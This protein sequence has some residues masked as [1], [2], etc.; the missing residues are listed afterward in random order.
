MGGTRSAQALAD[1]V[2]ADTAAAESPR[3][4]AVRRAVAFSVA[5]LVGAAWLLG[6]LLA[7][8]DSRFGELVSGFG[9][10]AFAAVG[11]LIVLRRPA[12]RLGWIFLATALAATLVSVGGLYAVHG[13]KAVPRWPGSTFVAWLADLVATPLVGLLAGVVPQLFP[14]GRPL[15]PRWRWPLAA[16]FGYMA[17]AAIGNGFFP[18]RLESVAGMQNPYAVPAATHQLAAAIALSALLGCAALVGTIAGLV[19]RW[20][21]ASTDERQQLKWFLAAVSLLPVPLLLHGVLPG[22][23]NPTLSIAFAL[24]PLAI[25]VAILRYRL[26][27]L[28]LLISR[29]LGYALVSA[30]VVA[31]YLAIVGM[32]ALVLGPGVGLAWQIV[33]TV[34]AAAA[35]QPLL[36]RLQRVVDHLFYGERSRPY[37]AVAGLSRRLEGLLEQDLVLPT[38]VDTVSEAL[39]LPYVAI[40]LREPDGYRIAAEHGRTTGLPRAYPMTYQGEEVGRMLACA[41]SGGA[42]LDAVD[43]ELLADLARQAGVA[44]QAVRAAIALQRSRAELVTAREEERRRLRRDLHDGLG[45]ALAGVTLGLHAAQSRIATDPDEAKR[46]VAAIESQVEEAVADIRRLVY[47]LRPPALDEFGLVR[48]LQLHAS[49]IENDR[50]DL[51]VVIQCAPEGLA[52]LPAA[53]EVAAYRIVVEALTNVTRHSGARHCL[54]QLAVNGALQLDVADDGIGFA[55]GQQAGVGITSMRER[56]AELGGTFVVEPLTPGTRVRAR[57]PIGDPQ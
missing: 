51:S 14:T 3:A 33:A 5:I 8:V 12:N 16:A 27:D 29:A 24:L 42:E 53:V 7:V 43:A 52:H 57:L 31:V 35:F 20:R 21:R 30:A 36:S 28:D 25:G 23:A 1:S 22:F 49:R 26:Y 46:L 13:L 41:R 47:G 54:V 48:A 32:A 2:P 40:E 50:R 56:A 6:V 37:Q 9:A 15:S 45:P 18:Q 10:M 11:V 4:V 38:I 55:L 19:V 17:L 44:A 39:R 34:V